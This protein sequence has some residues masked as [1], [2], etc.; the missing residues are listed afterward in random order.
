[1]EAVPVEMLRGSRA[2]SATVA[3][4]RAVVVMPLSAK[5]VVS[6]D[7]PNQICPVGGMLPAVP[8]DDVN[9]AK[10]PSCHAPIKTTTT[11]ATATPM[12]T[13]RRLDVGAGD[14]QAVCDGVA[15][16]GVPA[17]FSVNEVGAAGGVATD[18]AG[19]RG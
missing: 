17:Y 5:V 19:M 1:M 4:V 12:T 3:P 18:W 7:D 16:K 2:T 11:S 6:N 8:P 14:A 13:G 15:A 9:R 10:R